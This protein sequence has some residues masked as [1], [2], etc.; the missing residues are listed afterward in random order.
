M[1]G[2]NYFIPGLFTDLKCDFLTHEVCSD[3]KHS[4][5]RGTREEIHVYINLLYLNDFYGNLYLCNIKSE[6]LYFILF[7]NSYFRFYGISFKSSI[8]GI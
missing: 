8:F 7:D 3:E 1:D 2:G 4:R 6:C 5:R